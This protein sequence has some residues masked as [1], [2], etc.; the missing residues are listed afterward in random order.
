[1]DRHDSGPVWNYEDLGILLGSVFPCVVVA[2]LSAKLL[3]FVMPQKGVVAAISQILIYVGVSGS[4]YMMLKARY[5]MDFW[6]AMDWRVPWRHMTLT[7]LLGPIL[8]VMMA[9]LAFF[10]RTSRET[11]ALDS[12]MKDRWS[13]IA[14]G[15]AATT[16]GPVFEELMFRGFAQPLFVRS[17]GLVGGIVATAVPFA[18]LHGPQYN[19]KW[20]LML[21]LALASIV[22][23]IVRHL[24]GST[25]A[26]S[27]THSAYNLTFMAGSILQGDLLNRS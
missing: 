8:A 7:A 16:I 13:V 24:T 1:M 6:A 19:W 15:I 12:L 10:L 18:L 2:A 11:M 20:Q 14:I 21:I 27:L 5:G 26:S 4:L 22:F 3:S 17:L 25:A 23:G 9:L